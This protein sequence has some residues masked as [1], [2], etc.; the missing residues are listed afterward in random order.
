MRPVRLINHTRHFQVASAA[1]K[2]VRLFA[3]EL[4]KGGD[5]VSPLSRRR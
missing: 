1:L 2:E 3:A 4:P 5:N